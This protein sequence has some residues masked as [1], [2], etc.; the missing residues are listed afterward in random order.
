MS[1]IDEYFGVLILLVP[2][3]ECLHTFSVRIILFYIPWQTKIIS[4]TLSSSF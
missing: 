3:T 1:V 2:F 4:V